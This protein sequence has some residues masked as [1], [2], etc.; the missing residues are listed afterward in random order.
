MSAASR[1]DDDP[2]R[3]PLLDGHRDEDEDCA[4]T[5][6]KC[7]NANSPNASET[8]LGTE[9]KVLAKYSGPLVLT[10]FIQYG[11]QMVIILVASQLS[12]DELAGVSLGITTANILGYAVFEG[13]A[14]CL[15]TL[16]SQSYGSGRLSEVGLWIIRF[17]ILVHIVAIPIGLSWLFSEQ[18]LRALVPSEELAAHAGTFLRYS[19]IGVPGYASFEAGKRF[20]QAQGNFTGGLYTLLVCLPITMGLTYA[21]VITA[22]MRVAGAALAASLT[23]L[24]RP[25]LLAAY[26]LFLNRSTLKCW[27]SAS[28]IRSSWNKEYFAMLPL[29]ASGT[30]MTL[31]EWLSFEIL[32]F[33]LTY[34]GN[35]PLAAQT[36]LSTTVVLVC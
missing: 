24:L 35:A 6:R 13:M 3:R 27:P 2:E 36:F 22:D 12:T 32:T 11:F 20:L 8:S 31:S 17:T 23:N 1:P 28:E 26:S 9:L 25:L 4:D 29:A 18:I 33:S 30:V 7:A 16:C 5:S 19:L 34:L 21:L 14:T 15:D 10:Y